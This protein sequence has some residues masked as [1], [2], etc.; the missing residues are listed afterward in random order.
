VSFLHFGSLGCVAVGSTAVEGTRQYQFPDLQGALKPGSGSV[1][2]QIE[3]RNV[4]TGQNQKD[5]VENTEC[6]YSPD[7]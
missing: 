6:L 2:T 7:M 3:G 1:G 5:Y 4:V